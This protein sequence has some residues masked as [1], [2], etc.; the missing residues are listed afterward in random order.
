MEEQDSY[1]NSWIL[2]EDL[3]EEKPIDTARFILAM[4]EMQAEVHHISNTKGWWDTWRNNGES[5]ALMHS[6]LSEALEA[7]RNGNPP[8]DK[9]PEFNSVAVEL[10]DVI[11]RIM[12]F[13]AGKG[14]NVIEAL[15]SK[16]EYNRQREYRHGKEF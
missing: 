7:M 6:E 10:A 14:F 9:L 12:D 11:I 2:D 15:V 5:I 4:N 13:A 3:R 16:V 8:D 1:K